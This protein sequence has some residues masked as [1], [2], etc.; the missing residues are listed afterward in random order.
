[1]PKDA[2]QLRRLIT[3]GRLPVGTVLFH[4]SLKFPNKAIR[5]LVVDVGITTQGRVYD[6]PSGAA[7]S[8][9]DK[10]V[11]GWTYWRV[12]GDHELLDDLRKQLHAP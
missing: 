10:P 6:T 9:T 4:R 7:R 1:M 8:I 2:D 11:N 12:S 5:A 3:T